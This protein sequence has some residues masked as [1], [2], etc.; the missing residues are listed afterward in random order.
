MRTANQAWY[1][2]EDQVWR[3]ARNQACIQTFTKTKQ[4][5]GEK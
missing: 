4:S 2:V 1:Q 5:I 3:Q